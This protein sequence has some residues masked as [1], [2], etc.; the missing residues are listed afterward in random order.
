M[1]LTPLAIVALPTGCAPH[2]VLSLRQEAVATYFEALETSKIERA[3][4][5]GDMDTMASEEELVKSLALA[6]EAIAVDPLLLPAHLLIIQLTSILNREDECEAH[7]LY[8][9]ELFPDEPLL[10]EEA[11]ILEFERFGDLERANEI[12]AEGLRR[13]PHLPEFLVLQGELLLESTP[14]EGRAGGY[15]EV[16]RCIDTIL[17]HRELE[18]I[19]WFRLVRIGI[20]L[21]LAGASEPAVRPLVELARRQPALL[22]ESLAFISAAGMQRQ[23]V[24]LFERVASRADAGF[25]LEVAAAQLLIHLEEAGKA[26]ELIE[27]IGDHAATTDERAT[28]QAL[29]GHLRWMEGEAEKAH[30]LFRQA[31]EL[32]P[33][34]LAALEGLWLLHVQT[35]LVTEEEITNALA[36]AAEITGDPFLRRFLIEKARSLARARNAA[37]APAGAPQG[38]GS[39]EQPL[40]PSA[41]S[42]R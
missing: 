15:D 20:R 8:L 36:R 41:R 7:L 18:P 10:R 40:S 38:A 22:P 21:D 24:P 25:A 1:I 34:S 13:E 2:G 19:V 28:G 3:L 26:A 42:R 27:R 12:L 16:A 14:G 32:Q 33:A 39:G 9:L 23:A 6:H 29:Q 4:S 5:T 35:P 31:L 30:T 11:V 37:S 17:R